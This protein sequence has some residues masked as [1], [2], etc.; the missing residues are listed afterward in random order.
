MTGKQY[1]EY[2]ML[3][4]FQGKPVRFCNELQKIVEMEP[5]AEVLAEESLDMTPEQNE[6]FLKCH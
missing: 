4:V 6:L 2:A 3:E 1:R 5:R